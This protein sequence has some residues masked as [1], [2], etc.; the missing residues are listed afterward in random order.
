M[1]GVLAAKRPLDGLAD[2]ARQMDVCCGDDD[3]LRTFIDI[4]D[5]V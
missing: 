4:N 2:A 5:P 3:R 1:R